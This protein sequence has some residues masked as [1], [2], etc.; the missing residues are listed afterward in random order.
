MEY[1]SV[2]TEKQV[3]KAMTPLLH[4]PNTPVVM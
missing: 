1:W 4:T 2:E 3:L